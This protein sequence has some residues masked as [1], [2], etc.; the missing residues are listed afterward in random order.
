M[1]RHTYKEYTHILFYH[2]GEIVHFL[3]FGDKYNN[4]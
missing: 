1:F 2:G 4:L 3:N